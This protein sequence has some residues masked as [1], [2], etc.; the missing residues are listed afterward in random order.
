MTGRRAVRWILLLVACAPGREAAPAR[1][2]TTHRAATS[3]PGTPASAACAAPTFAAYEPVPVGAARF[4]VNRA[5]RGM[6]STV[7]WALSPDSSALLVVDDPVSVE[8][9][10][11]PDGALLASERTGRVWRGD[12]LWS[13][14]PSP[15][16]RQ[17]AFGR[18]TM[19][20]GGPEQRVD[21]SRWGGAAASL[22][23]VAGPHPLLAADS[24][25]AHSFPASGMGVME[26]AA[27]TFVADVATDAATAPVRLLA[28]DGWR[29]RWSCDGAA[30]LVGGAPADARDDA[31]AGPER[32]IRARDAGASDAPPADVLRWTEGPTL[33]RGGPRDTAA[34]PPLRVRG[35]IIEWREGRVVVVEGATVRDVGP[36]RPLAATRGGRFILALA[37]RVPLLPPRDDEPPD[38]A[39]VYRVP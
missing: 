2:D 35:R 11:V 34:A 31:A 24:L 13:V 9:D 22:A 37:P 39:V 36:G 27:A 23:R 1:A 33:M 30:V 3:A 21:P 32:R 12:S 6:T 8:G 5:T 20:G 10:P 4:V 29:V 17:I 38:E 18:A 16:W 7:R 19:L 25:R 26:S 14:A 28:L 15:D